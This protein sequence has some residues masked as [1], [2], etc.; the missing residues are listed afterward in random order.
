MAQTWKELTEAL[1]ELASEILELARISFKEGKI[2]QGLR[3][4]GE[5]RKAIKTAGELNLI[6]GGSSGWEEG[7][8]DIED[9]L[10]L[11]EEKNPEEEDELE[12]ED[13]EE[14]EEED[15]EEV[16]ETE[17][18]NEEAKEQLTDQDN[19]PGVGASLTL[20]ELLKKLRRRGE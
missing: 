8:E 12:D 20:E 2:E 19:Y 11:E 10:G 1:K 17:D 18:E 14:N 6:A 4:M 9:L 3:L 5:F 13:E 16:E 7:D 15:E